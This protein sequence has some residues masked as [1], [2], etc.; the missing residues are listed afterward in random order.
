MGVCGLVLEQHNLFRFV[1]V[2]SFGAPGFRLPILH[3]GCLG[4]AG[5]YHSPF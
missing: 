4:P 3:I 5:V 1:S 2:M